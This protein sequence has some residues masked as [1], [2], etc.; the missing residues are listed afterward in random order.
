[1]NAV[2]TKTSQRRS[3]FKFAFLSCLVLLPSLCPGAAA[4]AGGGPENVALVVNQASRDS[5]TIANHYMHLRHIPPRNVIYL[6]WTGNRSE[7]DFNQ[8]RSEI[9][10]PVLRAVAQRGLENQIDHVVY[11]CDFPYRANAPELK[12]KLPP[13]LAPTASI[14]SATFLCRLW[15]APLDDSFG[16]LFRLNNNFY[17]QSAQ[18]DAESVSTRAFRSTDHWL[19]G[20]ASDDRVGPKYLLSMMLGVTAGEGNTV[21]EILGYLKRSAEA[22]GSHPDGSVFFMKNANVRS[23]TRQPLFPLAIREL[24]KLS[25][26]AVEASGVLPKSESRVVGLMAGSASFDWEKSGC[27]IVPGAIC[28]HLTSFGGILHHKTGQTP[29]SVFLRYGAA[30]STGTVCEPYAIQA[31]FPLPTMHVHYA[32][33]A[34]AA[35]A[36]YQSVAAPFQLLAVGD[37][38]CRPWAN[39][40]RVDILGVV[41][42]ATAK[43]SIELTPRAVVPGGAKAERMDLF[44]DGLRVASRAADESFTIDTTLLPDGEHELRV[45]AIDAT[46]IATQGRAVVRLL[47]D[48]HG[49]RAALSLIEPAQDSPVD[50][51]ATYF[52]KAQCKGADRIDVQA[53]GR[54]ISKLHEAAGEFTVT[55]EE[56][57][58]GPVELQAQAFDASGHAIAISRI[59]RL[60]HP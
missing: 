48:N 9:I 20:G 3:Y 6:E 38:L 22:D 17:C 19:P 53:N 36:L 11:S 46:P 34:T 31:K 40:P 5:K 13:Q 45:V 21:D 8:L 54:T 26:G 23:T 56:L 42:G 10:D 44:I 55:G 7:T 35:E 16:Q 43:G 49:R 28:E 1:M 52:L 29:L 57:G 37:P 18:A 15:K 58:L 12:A 59:I 14:T 2:M 25:V 47:V 41:P 30:V 50:R 39:I 32:R 33:G 60:P 27:E 51:A 24:E 4:Y